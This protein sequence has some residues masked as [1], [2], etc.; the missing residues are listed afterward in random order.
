M[1]LITSLT[2]TKIKQVVKLASSRAY[3]YESGLAVIYG[4]HLVEEAIKH[5]LLDS[6]FISQAKFSDYD[7][8]TKSISEGNIYRVNDEVL[9]K[10]NLSDSMTDIVGLIKMRPA[11]IDN[12][13]Y[14]NDCVILDNIRDPGNLGTILRSCAACNIKNIILSKPGV[15][16]YNIKVLRAS[17]GIQFELNIII[18]ANIIEF[19]GNYKHDV[20][21]T[22]PNAKD[23]IYTHE[24]RKPC[25]WIFGNEGSGV[26]ELLLKKVGYK[27]AI[28]MPGNSESLNVAMAAT[29][30]L[31]EMQRQRSLPGQ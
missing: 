26:S 23:S 2:N 7:F 16:P 9:A 18:L 4:S 15:D 29:V 8:I 19:I 14:E 11:T 31:F 20:I 12:T 1:N 13:V 6:I 30:C 5:N 27:L 17:Q 25:A 10:I 28:P 3:R 22:V 24:L 21:A